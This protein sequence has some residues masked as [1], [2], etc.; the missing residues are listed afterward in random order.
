MDRKFNGTKAVH[1]NLGN[2][3]E[4]VTFSGT[5]WVELE[6]RKLRKLD[7]TQEVESPKEFILYQHRNFKT[8][9]KLVAFTG[10]QRVQCYS[11]SSIGA[12]LELSEF[13]GM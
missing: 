5:R 9:Y 4:L 2:F 10:T 13:I 11:G 8:Y 3:Y 7:A 6:I 1:R 12:Y